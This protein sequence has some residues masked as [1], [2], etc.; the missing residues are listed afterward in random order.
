MIDTYPAWEETATYV[1]ASLSRSQAITEARDYGYPLDEYL[2]N[3]LR[4][5]KVWMRRV[6]GEEAAEFFEGESDAGWL[7]E[8]Y[9]PLN[10]AQKANLTPMWKVEPK[11]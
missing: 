2:R 1:D 11:R 10:D 6:E 7:E 9:R 4:A 5:V 8:A 3:E